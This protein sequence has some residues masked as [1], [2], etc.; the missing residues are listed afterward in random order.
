MPKP[1]LSYPAID[2]NVIAVGAV[3]DANDGGPWVWDN[4]ARD[5]TTGPDRIVSFSQRLPGSGEVFAPG[6]LITG[7]APDDGTSQLSGTST[8]AAVVSGVVVL[9]QQLAMQDSGTS[10]LDGA[11]AQPAELH[12]RR[13]SATASSRTTTSPTPGHVF[14]V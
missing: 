2:P 10:A 7:A 11:D 8:A 5:N 1:G 3:W 9:A 4:G 12:G 13:R 6:T 14:P